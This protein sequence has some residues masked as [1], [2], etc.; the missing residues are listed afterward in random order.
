MKGLI[1]ILAAM[2]VA[3]GA[4]ACPNLKGAWISD[5]DLAMTFAKKHT[6]LEDRTE[7]FL[8]QMLG[9]LTM[10]FDADSVVYSLPDYDAEVAGKRYHMTG[11]HESSSY[12]VLFCDSRV[13]AVKGKQPVTG[14]E[15]ITVYNF[16]DDDTMWVYQDSADNGL[17]D[18]NIREYFARIK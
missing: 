1:A 13:V 8:D 10:R 12:Q 18:L 14:K 2:A 7:H 4:D 6:K 5:H 15:V 11:F 9:R 3:C 17:A 16:V